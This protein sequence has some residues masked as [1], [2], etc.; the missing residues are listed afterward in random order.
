MTTPH[1][2]IRSQGC[3]GLCGGGIAENEF[4]FSDAKYAMRI[5]RHNPTLSV[6]KWCAGAYESAAK[7]RGETV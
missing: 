7:S 4:A 5:Y 1:A 6:C 3:F 2:H